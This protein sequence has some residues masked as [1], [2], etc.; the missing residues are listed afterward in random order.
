MSML[1]KKEFIKEG[2]RFSRYYSPLPRDYCDNCIY[3]KDC[4]C[5]LSYDLFSFCEDIAPVDYEGNYMYAVLENKE[6]RI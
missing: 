3:S 1:K 6:D 2:I 5:E 4:G